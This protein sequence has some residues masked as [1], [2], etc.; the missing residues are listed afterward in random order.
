M[1]LV[2]GGA[3]FIGAN[4]VID[5]LSRHT[6]PIVN[7][8][9]LTCASNY[10]KLGEL[11]DDVRYTFACVDIVD[12]DA[13]HMLFSQYQPCAAVHF[14]AESHV[15]RSIARLHNFT[16]TN[17]VGK[18]TVLESARAY[19]SCLPVRARNDFR[20]LQVSTDEVY[21][22]LEGDDPP[23]T[24]TALNAPSGSR[25]ASK[26]ASGHQVRA[27]RHTYRLPTLTTNCSNN[28]GPYSREQIAFVT[29]RPGHDRRYAIDASKPKRELAWRLSETFD[30]GLEHTE[31]WFVKNDASVNSIPDGDHRRAC[32]VS[33]A[34]RL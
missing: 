23:L 6:E 18:A 2:T 27:W 15:G 17:V 5:W 3:G 8:D 33:Q 4:F 34:V 30:S 32:V 28:Y 16:E 9:K 14:A 22:S 25:A 10:R 26:A 31:P 24:E 19:W 1:I 7:V 20:F 12:H 21:G 13:T 29:G 11:R